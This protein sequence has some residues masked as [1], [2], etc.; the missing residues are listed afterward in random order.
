MPTAPTLDQLADE[1]I[2]TASRLDETSQRIGVALIRRLAQGA[3]VETSVLAGDAGLPET[4]VAG[5]LDRMPGVFRD[6]AGRVAL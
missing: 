1:I 4:E 6:E 5:R 2:E 3:P